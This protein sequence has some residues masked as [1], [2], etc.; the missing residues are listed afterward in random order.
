MLSIYLGR[1][2]G[3]FVS[4]KDNRHLSPLFLNPVPRVPTYDARDKKKNRD[5]NPNGNWTE[6]LDPV[7]ANFH[8]IALLLA[9]LCQK[10]R[11]GKLH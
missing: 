10:E 5:G 7:L 4:Y 8:G 2:V 6:L 11:R 3:R 1:I 9:S